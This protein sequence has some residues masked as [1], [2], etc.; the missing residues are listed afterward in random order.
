MREMLSKR[1]YQRVYRKKLPEENME[2]RQSFQET[3]SRGENKM[4]ELKFKMV[5]K[6]EGR[7]VEKKAGH[8]G[9]HQSKR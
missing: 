7:D 3:Q 1:D 6:K 8:K 9:E 2:R 5:N 4:T